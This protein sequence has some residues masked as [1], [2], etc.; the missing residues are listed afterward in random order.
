MRKKTKI[1]GKRLSSNQLQYEILKLFKR[2]PKKRFNPKQIIKKL[3]VDN[4]KDSVLYALEQLSEQT[5]LVKLED[6]KYKLRR[7]SHQKVEQSLHQ[8]KVDMTR[9]GS[10]YIIV[11]DMDNDVFI[12]PKNMNTALNGDIVRIKVWIPPGRKRPEG[13]V[14]EI[15]ERYADS[16]IGTFHKYK[17]YAIVVPDSKSLPM[18][19]M[20]D[21]DETMN[22]QNGDKVV[23]KL[24]EWTKGKVRTPV[25]KVTLVL[26]AS[27]SNDIEM[28][29]ILINNGFN[30]QFP[31]EVINQSEVLSEE[32]TEEEIAKRRDI[33]DI[34]T[35]TIDPDTAKD[36]DDALSFR[37][38]DNGMLE[39]GVHI[40]DVTHY[41]KEGTKLDEEAF[42]RSTSVYLV[43]RVLPML[44]ERLSNN[45]CSLRP[46][47]DRLTFSAIFTFDKDNK[48]IDRW[49]GKAIIHS[50]R[51]F[52]YG[53]AQEILDSGEGEFAVELNKL[54]QIA[55]IL[56]KR[57]FRDGAIDFDTEEVKFKLDEKAVP[58]DVYVKERKDTHMLIEEY[59]LLANKEVATYI[60]IKGSEE[61]IPFVY[62]VH[63]E[64][65]PDKVAELAK[66]ARELGLEM[67]IKTARDIGKS[68]NLLTKAAMKDPAFK[69]LQPI[70]IRTM[71]KAEYSSDNIGHYGLG[72]DNYSHFT[73]P[74]RRYSDVL[75]HRIL[76]L[77]LEREKAWRVNKV[78]LEEQCKHVSIQ[79]RRATDAERE[80]IKYKQ[81][82]YIQNHIGETFKGAISGIMDKGI[83]VELYGN[84]CEGM[85][86]FENMTEPFEIAASKLQIRSAYTGKVFK[87]GDPV[88][89]QIVSANLASRQ[90]EMA[91]LLDE[92]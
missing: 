69:V 38:L 70:A 37:Y 92:E 82:E 89:V 52:T 32:I 23:V 45:L 58:I 39:I 27:G 4:N 11:D 48:V 73:S 53:Q 60:T 1:K 14:V 15:V 29:S 66:F 47:V 5:H 55:K 40:A 50:D 36:F 31:E 33:R 90:I 16:F 19:I 34:V 63:D 85:A 61:E 88:T 80:S 83:F 68:Y 67:N 78:R 57:R 65:D 10:A 9:S 87:M 75:A 22:A 26:G 20:V 86:P 41:V 71:A 64:P 24:I 44:P 42:N 12:A 59:M 77:N 56:R 13:E 76:E 81:V 91:L 62:R 46:H 79:E 18:D 72:F 30:L 8:G 7:S 35:F 84:R 74:I 54:N 2:H 6:Y 49:F 25:G 28:K 17:A 3:K 21:L 43:D 51:R